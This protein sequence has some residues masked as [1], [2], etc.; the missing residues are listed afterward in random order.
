MVLLEQMWELGSGHTEVDANLNDT[1]SLPEARSEFHPPESWKRVLILHK[2]RIVGGST[3]VC[4]LH[5]PGLVASLTLAKDGLMNVDIYNST[6]EVVYLTPKTV[7]AN[8][9]GADV[10]I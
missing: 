3:F 8:I 9:F 5:R 6:E 2:A 1:F 7:L 10:F 4:G